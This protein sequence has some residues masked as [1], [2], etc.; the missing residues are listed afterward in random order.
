MNHM[1]LVKECLHPVVPKV[2]CSLFHF[3]VVYVCVCA[4]VVIA[5]QLWDLTAG[6]LLHSFQ[7]PSGSVQCLQFH[8]NEFLL[9]TGGS[10]RS[11]DLVVCK[12]V[13]S[14]HFTFAQTSFVPV[15]VLWS[16]VKLLPVIIARVLFSSSVFA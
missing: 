7:H 5:T 9:A 14:D 8:P 16:T 1:T 13:T 4:Y 10:D 11:E 12:L 6:K 15:L 2:T 3:I